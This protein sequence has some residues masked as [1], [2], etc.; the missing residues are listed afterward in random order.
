M[1]DLKFSNKTKLVAVVLAI[2][3]A[4]IPLSELIRLD[5]L[6]TYIYFKFTCFV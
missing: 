5:D 2:I 3:F 4:F 6:Y 1:L